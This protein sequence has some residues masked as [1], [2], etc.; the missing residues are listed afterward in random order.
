M[1]MMLSDIALGQEVALAIRRPR[2]GAVV[3]EPPAIDL[4]SPERVAAHGSIL[5][6]QLPRLAAFWAQP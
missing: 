3:D 6:Y 5:L 4:D 1:T 2:R